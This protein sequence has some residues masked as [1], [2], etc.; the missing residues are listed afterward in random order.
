MSEDC[1]LFAAV[2]LEAVDDLARLGE[3]RDRRV[4][5]KSA[6]SSASRPPP[7]REGTSRRSK[8][9]KDLLEWEETGFSTAVFIHIF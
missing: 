4:T 8:R 9:N 6:S 3:S 5:S 2:L 7:P 1:S